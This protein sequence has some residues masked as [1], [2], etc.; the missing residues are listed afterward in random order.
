[1]LPWLQM[2]KRIVQTDSSSMELSVSGDDDEG[3]RS[4]PTGRSES[5]PL[6]HAIL[7]VPPSANSNQATLP[8]VSCYRIRLHS[9]V[10]QAPW[11]WW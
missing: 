1:M 6:D 8:N 5:E 3:R 7:Q 9:T 11:L 2:S 4:S 10:F